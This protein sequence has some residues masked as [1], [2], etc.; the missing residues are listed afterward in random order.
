MKE[1]IFKRGRDPKIQMNIGIIKEVRIWLNKQ[2]PDDSSYCIMR[3]DSENC[4]TIDFVGDAVLEDNGI[5]GRFKI[6]IGE[7]KGHITI[8]NQ[9]TQEELYSRIRNYYNNVLDNC[10]GKTNEEQQVFLY[11]EANRVI[12]TQSG[13]IV[14]SLGHDYIKNSATYIR[15]LPVNIPPDDKI[16][17]LVNQILSGKGNG[18]LEYGFYAVDEYSVEMNQYADALKKRLIKI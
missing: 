7:H 3:E 16:K 5:K 9:L 17:E 10:L 6:K 13:T 15:S 8:I 2:K 11:G 4:F 12:E 18:S 1:I 14:I